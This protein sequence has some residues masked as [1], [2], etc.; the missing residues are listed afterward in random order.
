MIDFYGVSL[1]FKARSNTLPLNGRAASWHN[2]KT[3]GL[4][5]LCNGNVEDIRHFIFSCPKLNDIRTDELNRLEQSLDDNGLSYV[6]ELF[7]ASNIDEKLCILLGGDC[8]QFLPTFPSDLAH[9][10][11]IIMFW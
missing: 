11:N 4:C 9:T 3:S 1:K 10:A 8:T 6:W 7:I 5:D 2:S